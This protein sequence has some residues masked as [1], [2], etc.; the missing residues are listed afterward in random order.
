MAANQAEK[1]NVW[2]HSETLALIDIL[3]EDDVEHI[4]A[5]VY[6]NKEV[7]ERIASRLNEQGFNTT[8]Q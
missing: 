2:S 6:R 5:G 7:F 1:Y 8:W 4:L 3:G